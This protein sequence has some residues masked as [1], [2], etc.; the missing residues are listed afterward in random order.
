[1][2][3]IEKLVL[4]ATIDPEDLRLLENFNLIPE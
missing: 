4:D 1:M 2:D 3:S